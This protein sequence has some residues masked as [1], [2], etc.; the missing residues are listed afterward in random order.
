MSSYFLTKGAVV[1]DNRG[2][3]HENG[4]YSTVEINL[5]IGH[6]IFEAFSSLP[7]GVDICPLLE[8]LL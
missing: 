3:K 8:A 6:F 7:Q 1:C 4:I 5:T 2:L